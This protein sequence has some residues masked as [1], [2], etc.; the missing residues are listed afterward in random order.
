MSNEIKL[1]IYKSIYVYKLF[2]GLVVKIK[3]IEL[4][5]NF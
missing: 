3:K 1:L 2:N 5:N 4:F